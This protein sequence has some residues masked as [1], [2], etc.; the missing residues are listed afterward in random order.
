MDGF[1][2]AKEYV[3]FMHPYNFD[4]MRDLELK[5]ILL[6]YDKDSDGLISFIEFI[7]EGE[8]RFLIIIPESCS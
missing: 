3:T 8:G 4:H 5:E 6:D 1:L 7:G 2:E